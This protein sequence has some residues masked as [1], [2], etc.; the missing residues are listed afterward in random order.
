MK[1]T[2]LVDTS[3]LFA[4]FNVRDKFHKVALDFSKKGNLSYLVPIVVLPEI[5]FVIRR[6][7]GYDAIQGFIEAFYYS[8][9]PIEPVLRVDLQRVAEIMKIYQSAEF[10]L[11]DCCIMAL[12]ERLNITQICT[13]D[14]RDFS[15]FRPK[16]CEYF[17]LFPHL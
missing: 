9:I 15:I 16:H 10:D 5:T 17:E 11:V 4:L 14:R 6:D 1:M 13:F 12:A 7:M 8:D 3:Y 2:I